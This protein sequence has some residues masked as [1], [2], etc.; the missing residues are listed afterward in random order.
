MQKVI[1]EEKL[2]LGWILKLIILSIFIVLSP[3]IIWFLWNKNFAASWILLIALGFVLA[4][5]FA[6]IPRKYQILDDEIRIVMGLLKINIPFSN[7][8]SIETRPPSSIYVSFEGM[9]LGSGTGEKCI[10]IKR[11][12][13]ANI[14]IQPMNTKKFQQILNSKMASY[15]SAHQVYFKQ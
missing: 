7:I 15:R 8:D 5:F 9:R 12:R 6:I 2:K 11:K 13:G 10:L 1:Y 4:L 14:L 3:E